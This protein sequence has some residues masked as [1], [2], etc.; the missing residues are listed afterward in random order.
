VAEANAYVGVLLGLLLAFIVVR[1]WRRLEVRFAALGAVLIA[2]LSMGITIHFAGKAGP[3]PVFALGLVFPL[4][5]RY[6]PGRLMLYLTFFGWLALAL[7]PVFKNILPNRLMLFFYLLV[8]LLIA[9]WLDDM[10]AWQPRPRVLG[11][12]ALAASLVLLVP[13]L[14]FPSTLEAAPAFFAGGAAS[15]IPAGSVALVIPFS[16]RGETRAMIWQVQA[17]LR[18]RMPEGYAFIPAAPPRGDRVSPPPSATQTQTILVAFG[19][20]GPLTDQTRQQILRELKSWHVQTV[21]VGPMNNEQQEVDLF[22]SVLG[23]A[24]DSVDGVYVWWGVDT[25]P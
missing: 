11:W 8:G 1:Y 14:P 4:L 25:V 2:I 15:R 5:Q 23:R 3:I 16:A 18:F 13:A 17:G 24:P 9:V 22:T 19:R 20:A 12:L 10:K 21:V 6:L 7:L